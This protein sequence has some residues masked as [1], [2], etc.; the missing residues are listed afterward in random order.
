VSGENR[1]LFWL[2]EVYQEYMT[3]AET[4]AFDIVKWIKSMAGLDVTDRELAKVGHLKFKSIDVPG[5]QIT[6]TIYPIDGLWE[7][8]ALTILTP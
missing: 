2:D 3:L 4:V 6:V 5:I 7:D 1:V 8:V